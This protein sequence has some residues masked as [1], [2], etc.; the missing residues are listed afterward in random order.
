MR[1]EIFIAM[2][3]LLALPGCA[4]NSFFQTGVADAIAKPDPGLPAACS[5]RDHRHE[6]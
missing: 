6:R 3:T 4:E 2:L 1:F 5:Q